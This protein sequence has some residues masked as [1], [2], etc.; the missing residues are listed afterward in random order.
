MWAMVVAITAL[1]WNAGISTAAGPVSG[2]W[3]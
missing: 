2:P 1:S 3:P